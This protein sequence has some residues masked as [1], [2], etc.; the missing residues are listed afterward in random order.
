MYHHFAAFRN[1][2]HKYIYGLKNFALI[3]ISYWFLSCIFLSKNPLAIWDTFILSLFRFHSAPSVMT[4]PTWLHSRFTSRPSHF[5]MVFSVPRAQKSSASGLVVHPF[6]PQTFHLPTCPCTCTRA[7]FRACT[8]IRL[9][10]GS[11]G[12]PYTRF[13]TSLKPNSGP[14]SYTS[15]LPVN[16][17][18]SV[19]VPS[20]PMNVPT[21]LFYSAHLFK[22]PVASNKPRVRSICIYIYNSSAMLPKEF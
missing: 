1:Q 7:L 8:R 17:L 19:L 21:C 9:H 22:C 15:C 3:T 4:S 6:S 13:Y 18:D 11:L 14:L 12:L 10:I 2:V 20:T 16:G 5:N